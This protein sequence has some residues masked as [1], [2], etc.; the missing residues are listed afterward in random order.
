MAYGSNNYGK[1][2]SNWLNWLYTVVMLVVVIVA[3]AL[4]YGYNP[5]RSKE[6]AP[7]E[8]VAQIPIT[9]K[10]ATAPKTISVE[11]RK[12]AAAPQT[13]SPNNVAP[14]DANSRITA[15]ISEAMSCLN[16]QP[17]RI[18]EARDR[19]NDLLR[20]QLTPQQSAHIKEQLSA[21]S[22]KWL[23]SRTIF[24]QDGLC[25]TYTVKPGDIFSMIGRQFKVP[26]DILM[27]INKIKN[28]QSLQANQ[29][30]KVIN[31][32][33]HARVSRSAFKLDLY[34]QDTYVRTYRVGIGKAGMETPRGLWKAKPDGKL[35]RP[36][37]TDAITGK[38]Y[39][40]DSPDYPLGDRWISLEG[41]NGEAKD[42]TGF[43]IHG[44]N[45]P[46][47]IGTACS[48]GCIRML[49]EDVLLIYNLMMPG[50]S[51]VEVVD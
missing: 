37:W 2:K 1:K 43:A 26:P 14:M 3:I 48:Q 50:F 31:G 17:P 39:K 12:P 34:L 28:A 40:S 20:E 35:I 25:G 49:N 38:V 32:P 9:E 29:T 10:K 21:L 47:S 22:D 30:I 27:E 5:F 11:E 7:P 36:D 4:I 51:Q 13:S 19:L 45:E 46:N 33:F 24:P 6:T 44:T 15:G 8:P 42:K 23:F 41:I 18:I 16:A